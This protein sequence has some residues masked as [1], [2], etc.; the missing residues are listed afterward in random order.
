MA[1]TLKVS[2]I[3]FMALSLLATSEAGFPRLHFYGQFLADTSSGDFRLVNCTVTKVC[4]QNG[5]C[6][7]QD[8]IVGK[9]ITGSDDTVAAKMVDLDPYFQMYTSQLWGLVVGV[10]GAFQGTFKVNTV[11]DIW[12]RCKEKGCPGDPGSSGYWSSVLEN[13]SWF[14]N[15]NVCP[16]KT[17]GTFIDQ[18]KCPRGGGSKWTKTLN[19]KFTVDVM[20]EDPLT[21]DFA[22]GRVVGSISSVD[23]E[24]ALKLGFPEFNRMLW[25]QGV[26]SAMDKHPILPE[27]K[28]YNHAPFY[29]DDVNK[30]VVVDL[31]NSLP[32]HLNGTLVDGGNL[33]LLL[34]QTSEL[35]VK[36]GMIKNCEDVLHNP[37]SNVGSIGYTADEWLMKDAGIVILDIDGQNT[38]GELT[39]MVVKEEAPP[40]QSCQKQCLPILV[41]HP[42]GLYLG[43]AEDRVFRI[44]K[45]TRKTET[46][47]EVEED[48]SLW[49][50]WCLKT[51]EPTKVHWSLKVFATEFGKPKQDIMFIV[52]LSERKSKIGLNKPKDAITFVGDNQ[53]RDKS[54]RK[55]TTD[56]RGIAVIEFQT[57]REGLDCSKEEVKKRR[58]QQV[59]GQLY[60]YDITKTRDKHD[61]CEADE[62][63]FPPNLQTTTHLYCKHESKEIYYWVDDI[64][65]L[66]QRYDNLFPVMKP[67]FNLASYK[68]VIAK[69]RPL[70]LISSLKLALEDP[71][72]MPV[73]RDL[74]PAD[75][76]M[77]VKWLQPENQ[78]YSPKDQ[79]IELAELKA[80]LQLALRFEWTTIPLYLSAYYS[81]KDGFNTKVASLL[82]S[83]VIDEM[84]H[85]ALVA[86]II[87]A[88]GWKPVLNDPEVFPTY[89]G[90]LPAGCR[91]DVAVQLAKC[92]LHQIHDVFMAIEKAEC[93]GHIYETISSLETMLFAVNDVDG[94]T[95]DD[96]DGM[97]LDDVDEMLDNLTAKCREDVKNYEPDTIGALY[98]HKILCPMI[99]LSKSGILTFD[100][101]QAKQY[102]KTINVTNL[103]TAIKAIHQ[104]IDEGEGGDPCDPFY[105]DPHGNKTL[106]HYYKFAEIAHGKVLVKARSDHH[107][108]YKQYRQDNHE[109]ETNVCETEHR[110]DYFTPCE[111]NICCPDKYEFA[112]ANIPFFE[113]AVWPTLDNPTSSKYPPGS[114]ARKMSDRFNEKYTG[115]M[116]CLHDVFNGNPGNMEKCYG[117]MT[118]L[119]VNAKKMVQTPINPDGNPNVG[120]NVTP[121]FEWYPPIN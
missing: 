107:D 91:P 10:E 96:V 63:K 16:T 78:Q 80:N 12:Q 94:K 29:V 97:P 3:G 55:Y 56:D 64:Y 59:G 98:I 6:T 77:L 66:F 103:Q 108:A 30:K 18:L 34:V 93:A 72:H 71:N 112:G 88:I 110:H 36:D 109:Q 7:T 118:S 28:D 13:V 5:K 58:E 37:N 57:D 99:D 89:P 32:T 67:L 92:S 19:I 73:T 104:I 69:N 9:R 105:L 115:L 23:N 116:K 45:P 95:L 102:P 113:N 14:S 40:C 51:S 20:N 119:T 43:A 31:S 46:S 106:S 68:E 101:D 17:V 83:V 84:N 33:F 4:Y 50:R 41:E 114:R 100:G 8:P 120:P 90:P 74:S 117:L 21:H 121:T 49:G 11:M 15:K 42:E 47:V 60:I 2:L 75:R 82:K 24:E 53:C 76:D 54:R 44:P 81:I 70:N 26:I 27:M 79:K 85:M 87:N 61:R 52:S 48:G 65:P 22:H 38:E 1:T 25:G 86:N 111:G 62:D 35:T 39:V